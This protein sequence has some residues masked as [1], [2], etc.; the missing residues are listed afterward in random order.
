MVGVGVGQVMCIGLEKSLT[1]FFYLPINGGGGGGGM[2][3]LCPPS[4]AS[5]FT[6]WLTFKSDG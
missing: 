3:S 1:I 6:S 2:A 5:E 4:Y